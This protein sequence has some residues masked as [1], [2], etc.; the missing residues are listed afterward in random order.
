MDPNDEYISKYSQE[1]QEILKKVRKTIQ[2]AAPEAT[3]KISYGMPTSYLNKNL[4]H[5]AANKKHLGFYPTLSGIEEFKDKLKNYK[6]AK[7]AI[8]FQYKEPISYE[9]IKEIVKFRVQ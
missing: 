2:E 7:G 3:K 4:V 8:Q 9:I 1:T 6:T 5:F